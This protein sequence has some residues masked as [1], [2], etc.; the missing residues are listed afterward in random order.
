MYAPQFRITPDIA[1]AL[2]IIEA[3]RQAIDDL[4]VTVTLLTALRETARLQGTHH[5]TQIEGNR[6]TLA[7]VE[8]VISGGEPLPGQERDAGEC[9]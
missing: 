6:L 2:M 8:Q 3:C 5:S 9:H 1:K 4:P 7:Q